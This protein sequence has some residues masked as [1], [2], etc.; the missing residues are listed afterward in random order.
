[1]RTKY[2]AVVFLVVGFLA[3]LWI[4]RGGSGRTATDP[5]PS[6]GGSPDDPSVLRRAERTSG[7]EGTS[8][9]NQNAPIGELLDKA[10][11][12]QSEIRGARYLMSAL[13][14]HRAETADQF[15]SYFSSISFSTERIHNWRLFFSSWGTFDGPAALAYIRKRFNQT[16]LQKE[17]YYSVLKSW[18][19]AAPGDALDTSGD[20]LLAVPGTTGDLAKEFIRDLLARDRAKGINYM[21][22]LSDPEAVMEM[23]GL[24]LMGLAKT[25]LQ[26]A[27]ELLGQVDG[28]TKP[29]LTGQLVNAWSEF[30]PTSA[31]TW[32]AGQGYPAIS[33]GDLNALVANFMK[34]SPTAA[35]DWINKLP[36]THYS[37]S[38]LQ[39]A[40]QGWAKT[41]PAA[42]QA[43]L[44]GHQPAAE[45]DPVVI[46][47]V[48]NMAG[49]NPEMALKAADTQI[50]DSAKS[51]ETFFALA[52][53]WK[54]KQ[55]LEFTRWLEG[56]NLIN[57]PQKERLLN[58]E[59][60]GD[61]ETQ[62]PVSQ[63]ME[64]QTVN[65]R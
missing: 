53:E 35:F 65:G 32:L 50:H 14:R 39:H 52:M 36:D 33:S 61:G 57:S 42:T 37:E 54:Q 58:R 63:P 40:A 3:G 18:D 6:G 7:A 5:S 44:G 41:N 64:G 60:H 8:G 47:I 24:Q 28:E 22:R 56:T 10:F 30:D 23:A 16:S 13:A 55:P 9:N 34:V 2:I 25:N 43:W 45:F 4:P 15:A 20:F 11:S 27:L 21:V 38:L 49:D 59:F 26:S 46:A 62:A 31:A 29:Y 51:Q 1:M 17:F 19:K 12:E 48:Q